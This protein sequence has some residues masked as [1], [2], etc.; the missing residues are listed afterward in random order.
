MA[1][2]RRRFADLEPVRIKGNGIAT[3]VAAVRAPG[4]AEPEYLIVKD[5]HARWEPERRLERV[6]R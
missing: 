5:G 1:K 6:L 2:K 4:M 3:V